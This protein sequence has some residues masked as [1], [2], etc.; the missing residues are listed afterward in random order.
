MDYMTVSHHMCLNSGLRVHKQLVTLV[1][2]CSIECQA[3]I[4]TYN[5]NISLEQMLVTSPLQADLTE[6]VH[7]KP[8][9][10]PK[11][12]FVIATTMT[13]IHDLCPELADLNDCCQMSRVAQLT[14][15]GTI[16]LSHSLAV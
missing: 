16:L 13:H 3:S 1:G 11:K 15:Y 9:A 2:A 8:T 14:G 12:P 10:G 7:R 5:L 4:E 6:P